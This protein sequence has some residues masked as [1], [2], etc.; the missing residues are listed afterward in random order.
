MTLVNEVL[1]QSMVSKEIWNLY[2]TD[3]R[4]FK[5]RVQAY[6]ALGLPHYEVVKINPSKRIVWLRSKKTG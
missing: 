3:K 2:E 6:F 4:E 1:V 5:R